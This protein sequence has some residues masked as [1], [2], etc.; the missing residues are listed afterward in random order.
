MDAAVTAAERLLPDSGPD[1]APAL[2]ACCDR[3]LE[4]RS[5]GPAIH[6]WNGLAARKL[7]AAPPARP[8]A[9]VNGDFATEPTQ[10]GFDWFV[11]PLEGVRA[12]LDTPAGLRHL[13]FRQTTGTL[14]DPAPVRA[15]QAGA[16]VRLPH[17]PA[18]FLL[19]GRNRAT[20]AGVRA[21]PDRRVYGPVP[22]H[23]CVHHAAG[24]DLVRL[25]LIYERAPGTTR[26]EGEVWLERARLEGR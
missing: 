10:H 3:L 1:D 23:G 17:S 9:L 16:A 14:R 20:L 18:R 21:G 12:S 8:E 13:S 7:I 5:I 26:P 15:G 25:A 2:V 19:C 6:L 24:A 4:V 11:N 22:G